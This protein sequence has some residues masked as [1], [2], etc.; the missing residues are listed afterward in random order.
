[1]TSTLPAISGPGL[2][3]QGVVVLQIFFISLFTLAELTLRSGTGILT[4]LVIVVVTFGG[5]RF[6]RPGTRYVSVVTPPLVL[7]AIVTLYYLLAD[8]LALTRLGIDIVAA[9][10]SVGPWLLAAAL[11]GWFMFFNEKAK[12]QKP[13]PRS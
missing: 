1:M 13:K 3:K 5:I 12:S 4:G 9:L 11:Y 8:G 10:A 7:A 6:G 2:K